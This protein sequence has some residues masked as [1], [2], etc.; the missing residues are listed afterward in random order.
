[1]SKLIIVEGNK[2]KVLNE[3]GFDNEALLQDVVEKFPEVIALEDLGVTEPFMV[4][5]REVQTKA[6]YIDVLC[7]DGEGVLTVVETKLAKNAQIRREVIGQVLEYV[8]QLSKWRAQDVIQIANQYFAKEKIKD[9]DRPASLNDRLKVE[10]E[11]DLHGMGVNE[12]IEDNLR[13]GIIKL[14]IAS[15]SIPE[16]LKST[17]NFINS[18]SNFDIYVLQIQ[19]YNKDEMMIYSPTVFGFANKSVTGVSAE[20]TKWDEESFFN[21]ISD[22]KPEAIE[23]IKKLYKFTEENAAGISWGTGKK[24]SSFS[25]T[26][27]SEIKQFNIFAVLGSNDTGKIQINFGVMKDI[28]PD[29]ELYAFRDEINSFPGAKLDRNCVDDKKFPSIPVKSIYS[30]DDYKKFT[31]RILG[32]Q[33]SAG[34]HEDHDSL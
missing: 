20:R 11:E 21:S 30:S 19:S 29:D 32:L 17:V 1:M 7:I 34:N 9:G 14:V 22:L 4:I 5:G 25:Y 18:F 8:A 3:K 33:K 13:K 15:D 12:K 6:G 27:E 16:T 24:V 2:T 10:D 28:V 23:T 31:D 26:V